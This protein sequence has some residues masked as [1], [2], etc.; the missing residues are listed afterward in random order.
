MGKYSNLAKNAAP[1]LSK[2]KFAFIKGKY[3]GGEFFIRDGQK[4]SIGRDISSDVAIVDSK[5]SRHHASITSRAGR[6]FIETL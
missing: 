4:L 5:V 6:I 1:D 2:I 3:A